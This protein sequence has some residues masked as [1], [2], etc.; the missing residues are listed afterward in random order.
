MKTNNIW[1]P[2]KLHYR[3]L[4]LN[5]HHGNKL[6]IVD[7]RELEPTGSIKKQKFPS[8]NSIDVKLHH[9]GKPQEFRKV[10]C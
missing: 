10:N 9:E 3:Y 6:Y 1:M 5:L 8:P 4:P 2:N 7:S